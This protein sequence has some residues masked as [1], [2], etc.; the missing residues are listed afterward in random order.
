MKVFQ[1]IVALLA[2]HFSAVAQKYQVGT[3]IRVL[4]YGQLYST[5]NWDEDA[6]AALN[7]QLGSLAEAVILN[8]VESAWPEGIASLDAR[9]AN[10]AAFA[11]YTLFYLTTLAT[12]Q[13]VLFVPAIENSMMPAGMAPPK[14]IYFIISESATEAGMKPPSTSA[15]DLEPA[16]GFGASMETLTQD[17]PNLF[18][19]LFNSEYQEDVDGLVTFHGCNFTMEDAEL[20]YFI[21]D[22]LAGSTIFRAAFA[23]NEDPAKTLVTYSKL[24]RMVEALKLN[25]C[26]L[27]KA[28]EIVAGN[29]HT[30]LFHVNYAGTKINIDYQGMAIEVSTEQTEEMLED[31]NVGSVWVPVIYIYE[32]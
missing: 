15:P 32:E 7:T 19:N 25:C 20:M 10:Q 8:S 5:Y 28:T 1:F 12:G 2:F 22:L 27:L 3:P 26:P 4:D 16:V 14:D 13:V 18:I 11:G 24:V 31:G 30:Q 17:F 6:Q 29:K 21:D 23:G 9:S